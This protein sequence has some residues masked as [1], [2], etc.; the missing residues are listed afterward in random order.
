MA[1]RRSKRDR[2][3]SKRSWV[4]VGFVGG[5]VVCL[6]CVVYKLLRAVRAM[7]VRWGI[8]PDWAMRAA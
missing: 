2:V 3:D 5:V 8:R 1:A 4:V 7:E 6:V